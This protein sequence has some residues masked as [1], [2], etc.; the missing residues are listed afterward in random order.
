VRLNFR[1][2]ISMEKTIL[3]HLYKVCFHRDRRCGI[4]ICFTEEQTGGLLA[5]LMS[6]YA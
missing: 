3:L 6:M 4:F 1:Y 5:I 2:M